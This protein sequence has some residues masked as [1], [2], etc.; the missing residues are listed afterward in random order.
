MES[1]IIPTSQIKKTRSVVVEMRV[2][3]LF[4]VC[5]ICLVCL[6]GVSSAVTVNQNESIQDAINTL[7]N[8]GIIELTAGTWNITYPIRINKSNVILA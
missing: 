6:G 4:L 5:L 3:V 7:S 1:A 8:G 2:L